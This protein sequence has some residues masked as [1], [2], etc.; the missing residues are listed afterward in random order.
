M[1][2]FKFRS[3]GKKVL[4]L[5]AFAS[6]LLLAVSWVMSI[7]AYPRL[8][9]EAVVWSSLWSGQAVWKARS[10]SFFVYPLAQTLFFLVF[11]VLAKGAFL[12]V[13]L[14]SIDGESSPGRRD[15]RVTELKKEVI[16]L[17]LIF[18]NLVFIHLQTTL[19]LVSHGLAK[20]ISRFY[21]AMLLVV[22]VML[23]PYYRIRR[24]MLDSGSR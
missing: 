11:L 8:P 22:L 13:P 14:T 5:L 9:Q 19:I 21:F 23:I 15:G 17:G 7:Y 3:A 1:Q 18:F 6:W 12:R 20:G 10:A 24:R 2:R 4:A 16:Y